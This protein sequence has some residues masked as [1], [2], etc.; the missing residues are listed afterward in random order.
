MSLWWKITVLS[1]VQRKKI[2]QFSTKAIG[3]NQLSLL[4]SVIKTKG[5][6]E[7][8]RLFKH[9]QIATVIVTFIL[10]KKKNLKKKRESIPLIQRRK[11]LANIQSSKISDQLK[12]RLV[13]LLS[14][15][16][17]SPRGRCLLYP[18]YCR[19]S[20]SAGEW[21]QPT[22]QTVAVQ[23]RARVALDPVRSIIGPF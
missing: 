9:S 19:S 12:G 23:S 18:V 17:H 21:K 4:L 1:S 11:F 20:V 2:K 13:R 5:V 3:K 14:A 22:A 15:N 16:A 6:S 10:E 8:S 7:V